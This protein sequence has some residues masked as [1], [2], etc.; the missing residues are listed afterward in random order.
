LSRLLGEVSWLSPRIGYSLT[1]PVDSNGRSNELA[2]H[3]FPYFVF[4]KTHTKA[5]KDPNA[6]PLILKDHWIPLHVPLSFSSG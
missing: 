6:P 2:I 5:T 3:P 4:G 1:I